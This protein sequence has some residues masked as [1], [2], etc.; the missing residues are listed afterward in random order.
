MRAAEVMGLK[1]SLYR[2]KD[3]VRAW[4]ETLKLQFVNAGRLQLKSAPYL[5]KFE[6]TIL[7]CYVNDL[8]IFFQ[9]MS[10]IRN[11]RL[12]L[13]K[14]FVLKDSGDSEQFLNMKLNWKRDNVT[15]RQKFNQKLVRGCG[16]AN[17]QTQPSPMSPGHHLNEMTTPTLEENGASY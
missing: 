4:Y 3:A 6:N 7:V 10:G 2:S 14:V 13:E 9:S 17:M 1:C 11:L 12:K 16:Y 5:F 15:I 8:F